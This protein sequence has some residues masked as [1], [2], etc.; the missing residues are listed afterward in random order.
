MLGTDTWV[1][2]I[3]LGSFAWNHSVLIIRVDDSYQGTPSG[4]PHYTEDYA[5]LA[6]CTTAPKGGVTDA[7]HRHC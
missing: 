2:N 4:V 5:A 1:S 6:A 7:F 3:R